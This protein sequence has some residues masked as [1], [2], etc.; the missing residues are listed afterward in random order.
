MLKLG[1]WSI[2]GLV[3]AVPPLGEVLLVS[4]DP[5][6][7]HPGSSIRKVDIRREAV[8]NWGKRN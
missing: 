1:D 3:G 5:R 8:S 4:D 7:R 2:V 6:S